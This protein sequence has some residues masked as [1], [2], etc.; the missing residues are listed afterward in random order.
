MGSQFFLFLPFLPGIPA[1][2]ELER[3]KGE[4]VGMKRTH[5][6][7]HWESGGVGLLKDVLQEWTR[8]KGRD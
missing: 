7:T 8:T 2:N 1:Q 5:G 4:R 3:K 6:G